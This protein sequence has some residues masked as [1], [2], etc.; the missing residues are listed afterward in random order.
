MVFGIFKRKKKDDEDKKKEEEVVGK[1]VVCNKPVKK[2]EDYRVL[3]FQGQ[4]III[5]RKCFK[6]MKKLARQFLKGGFSI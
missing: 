3:H 6:Q 4:K 2:I 5:H 1:C